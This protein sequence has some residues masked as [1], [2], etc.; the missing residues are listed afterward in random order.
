MHRGTNPFHL[1]STSCLD[2]GIPLDLRNLDS[3]LATPSLLGLSSASGWPKGTSFASLLTESSDTSCYR[4][5][6]QVSPSI[7]RTWEIVWSVKEPHVLES[8]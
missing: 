5:G 3:L 1:S 6:A 2:G 8:E 7:S 4:L